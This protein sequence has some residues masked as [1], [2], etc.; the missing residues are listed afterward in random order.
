MTTRRAPHAHRPRTLPAARRVA[1]WLLIAVLCA[2]I[3]VAWTAVP[4]PD[5]MAWYR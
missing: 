4:E 1:R 5:L 2:L 3:F